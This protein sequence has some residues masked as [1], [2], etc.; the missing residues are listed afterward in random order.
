MSLLETTTD[1]VLAIAMSLIMPQLWYPDERLPRVSALVV[2]LYGLTLSRRYVMRRIFEW[3]QRRHL[4]KSGALLEG[5]DNA[6][7]TLN[8]DPLF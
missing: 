6:D 1:T 3:L 5:L 4:A 8:V 2:A 7:P